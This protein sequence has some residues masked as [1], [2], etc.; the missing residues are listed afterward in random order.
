MIRFP[1][2]APLLAL[3]VTACSDDL[4]PA[5]ENEPPPEVDQCTGR[6]PL[7]L[8]AEPPRVRVGSPVSLVATGGSGVYRYRLEAG[9]SSG[10]L[11]AQRFIAGLTPGTDTLV[12]EDARCEG[13]A[14]AT[15]EVTALF[16]IA[17]ARAQLR[18]GTSFQVAAKGLLGTARYNLKQNLSGGSLSADGLYTAG[19]T[20]GLDLITV[21]DSQTGDEAIL[22]YEVSKTARLNGAPAFLAAPSGSS[23]P[24]ATRGGSDRVV[25]TKVSGPGTIVAGRIGFVAGDT[26][27][28]VLE[29]ADPFTGDK[30]SVTVVV[31]DELTRPGLA[32]G[33]LTD[34]ATLVTADFD[35]DGTLDLAV[36]QRESDMGRPTGGAVFIY[37]G[38]SGGLEA[39]PL[40]VL[41]GDTDTAQFGDALAAGDL[42]GDGRAELVVSSPG[43]DV[44]TSNAGAVYLYTF[45]G[46]APAPLRLQLAG[47]LRDAAFGAGLSVADMDGDGKVDLVVGSPAGDLAPSN[48]IRARGTVDIYLA[49]PSAP[50]PDLPTIRLG[51]SDLSREGVPMA[52][53]GSDLGRALVTADFNK[54][55][56]LDI[57]ALS[58]VSRYTAEGAVSGT[59][60]AI[61]VFFA[62]SEGIRFRASPDVY[63]L[64]ANLADGNEGTW[65]LAAIPANDTRPPLL[66]AVA[67]RADS[68]DLS[69]SGGVRSGPDSGGALLFDLSAYAPTGD[70]TTTPPQVKRE[71]AFAR[72]YGDTAGVVAGRSFAVLDVDGTPGPELVL[73]AP[74]A[75]PPGPGGTTLR[76]GGKVLVYPLS[77]LTKGAVINKSL[78][79][80]NGAAKS[81]TLGSGLAVWRLPEGDSLAAFSG[82]AS[83]EQGAF[84]GRV[85]L[86]RRGGAS[87]VEWARTSAN[88]PAKPSVERVG[89][90]VAVA[91]GPKGAVAL[92]G[93]PGWSGPGANGDGD[94]MSIGRAYVRG[95]A[96]AAP[97]VVAEEGAP[98][99]HKAGRTVGADVA[100]TDFDGDKLPDLVVGATGF[101]VPASNNAELATTYQTVRPECLTTAN[102]SVGGL[103]V[104]LGQ[105]DGSFKPAYRV[106]APL[107]IAGCTPET[108]AKCKRSA[109]GRGLVGGFDFNGDGNQDVGVLR[110]RGMEVFLGRDPDDT[111]LT[112]LTMTCDSVYS[113]PSLALQTSAPTSLGDINGDSCDDLAW[114][115]AEGARSGVAI[116]FGYNAAGGRCGGRTTPTVWRIAG[117]SEVQLN[118]LGLGLAIARAGKVMSNAG[119]TTGDQ[120]DFLAISA[121][122]VPFNGVTQPV[123]LLFDKAQLT[124]EMAKKQS[125]GS[126][127]VVGAFGDGLT[128]VVLVHKSR[129]VGFGTALAGNVDLSGDNVPDLVVSAP[130][131]SEASDGGGAVFVYA[132]AP[133]LSGALSPY[134]TIAGDGAERAQL[135]QDLALVPGSGGTPPT[136]VIGAP[137]SFRT[138]TQNGTA[139]AL[140][141]RF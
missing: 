99:P 56:R 94:A 70:P 29:A 26:G 61:S 12:V 32:H 74:Y 80:L 106:W 20:E 53:T 110:D 140:P 134:F 48:N 42:D 115:Y 102:Q 4:D 46:G 21:L 22:Q 49:T 113:W 17:P 92:L 72:I 27:A 87:L 141:L 81:D 50:V 58:R 13:D 83:S 107:Q 47:L 25:W 136:M 6:A 51:G 62:R 97:A 82:R 35:G 122:A 100:F 105:A 85:E 111:S 34:A 123:V 3:L 64:P 69:T 139:F 71:E 9:G 78:S 124:T 66:M 54:D 52:R 118:N 63:V 19:P 44:A 65:R 43:A 60:V 24:L 14:R 15:L 108:D 7:T 130:G 126:P 135:G 137:R 55:G 77:T 39:Q 23:V 33:R 121:T 95:V 75:A 73:G 31:L 133:N 109:L 59:Q 138:G 79:A 8:R 127:L 98:S 119:G 18:P 40:W 117:D 103:L 68:P 37:K 2:A 116:L 89:E 88:V 104:S 93:A 131:A 129:A 45:K 76:F 84:T 10:E 5:R 28:A 67:D 57:A 132:G 36:G 114:R 101:V 120:R 86:F 128:P 38:G 91:V 112:K 16:D 30:A 1:R 11:R 90:Q 125:A 41:T 96:R